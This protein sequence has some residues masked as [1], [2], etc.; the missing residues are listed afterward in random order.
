MEPRISKL[1]R[2]KTHV[3]IQSAL[4]PSNQSFSAQGASIPPRRPT[5]VGPPATYCSSPRRQK[6]PASVE[7]GR[8]DLGCD[9][10]FASGAG[11]VILFAKKFSAEG[12][13]SW[14]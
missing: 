10:T 6:R 8:I 5:G 4:L 11:R 1:R 2:V 14:V 12:P 3:E 7:R 9:P 13:A